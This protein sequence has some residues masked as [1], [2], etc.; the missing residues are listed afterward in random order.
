MQLLPATAAAAVWLPVNTINNPSHIHC[1]AHTRSAT[2]PPTTQRAVQGKVALLVWLS[3]CTHTKRDH[4]TTQGC[5]CWCLSEPL[6]TAADQQQ[7]GKQSNTPAI[8]TTNSLARQ[9]AATAAACLL[10]A[11]L[12]R[13]PCDKRAMLNGI[14]ANTPRF[15]VSGPK[16][17]VSHP[18][19]TKH[20]CCRCCCRQKKLRGPSYCCAFSVGRVPA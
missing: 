7:P 9:W 2:I 11:C 12:L 14:A 4:Q 18:W 6:P 5:V 8:S 10:S 19:P 15:S 1:V 13:N 20:P 17:S 3:V 16:V